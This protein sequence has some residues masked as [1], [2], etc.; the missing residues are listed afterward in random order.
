MRQLARQGKNTRP[1]RGANADHYRHKQA[2]IA[3]EPYLFRHKRMLPDSRILYEQVDL[4]T[5]SQK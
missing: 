4:K 1:H 3:P 5:P 2:H